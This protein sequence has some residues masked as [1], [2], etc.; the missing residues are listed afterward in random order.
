MTPGVLYDWYKS[1]VGKEVD[2]EDEY[3]LITIVMLGEVL[4]GWLKRL[5]NGKRV[6]NAIEVN[7][8]RILKSGKKLVLD[9][10]VIRR[11]QMIVGTALEELKKQV[12]EKRVETAHVVSKGEVGGQEG[13]QLRPLD[14]VL[15]DSEREEMM[16]AEY[17]VVF[18]GFK[19]PLRLS[20]SV[21]DS[22]LYIPK[23]C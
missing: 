17:K 3:L 16:P 15:M 10:E 9:E 6:I 11:F 14:K 4:Q 2:L 19:D 5:D 12:M 8:E 22:P 1:L 21:R 20:L 13:L 23:V 18:R 7:K